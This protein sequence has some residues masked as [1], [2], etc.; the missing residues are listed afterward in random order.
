M[1][2]GR[3]NIRGANGTLYP[4][5][6]GEGVLYNELQP[7]LDS[8]GNPRVF[9]ITNDTVGPLY[10]VGLHAALPD[11]TLLTIP[12]GEK[13]KTLETARD[14]YERLLETGADR[15]CVILALG[16]GVIGDL[17]GFVAATYLRGVRLIQAPTTLLAMVDASIGGKVGVDLPQGKNLV[18]AFKDPIAIVQ[19]PGVLQTLPEV[20]RRCGLAEIIKAGLI[21]DAELFDLLCRQPDADTQTLIEGAVAVK[22]HIVEKD[23]EERGQRAWLNLGHTFGH[24]IEVVSGYQVKHGLAVA[25]GLHAAAHLSEKLGML[26][27][28]VTEQLR[29]TLTTHGLPLTHAY[30]PEALLE[31]MQTDK[32]R[33][34][35]K[36]RFALLKGVGKP[37]LRDDVPESMLR[38]TLEDVYADPG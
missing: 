23:R 38:E 1:A 37:V 27:S 18:G 29:A 10:G 15:H 6:S 24:A 25:I 21:G 3:L 5:I 11:S 16:G 26:N 35:G 9:T 36:L 33:R 22:V 32:K 13:Y 17:A 8:L 34:D 12:D 28:S 31:A 19:D 30:S 2:A 14:L 7:F 20:E 4:L